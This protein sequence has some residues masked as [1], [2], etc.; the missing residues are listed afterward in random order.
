MPPGQTAI[1]V[2][3][4]LACPAHGF[5]QR[6]LHP[7]G[8]QV[9]IHDEE[10]SDFLSFFDKLRVKPSERSGLSAALLP[11]LLAHLVQF[12]VDFG[13]GALGLRQ[14]A[15]ETLHLGLMQALDVVHFPTVVACGQANIC[16][17]RSMCAAVLRG[18]ASYDLAMSTM[19]SS[20]PP[21]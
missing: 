20:T 21:T 4:R 18:E 6:L 5:H 17:E 1:G 16:A 11:G 2:Y 8:L 19:F 13:V 9:P 15:S 12:L 14:S 7:E 10:V 3:I